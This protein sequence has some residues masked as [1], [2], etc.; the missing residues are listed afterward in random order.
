MDP[1]VQQLASLCRVQV[2]RCK[3]VF[4]P[5]HAVGRTIGERIALG[6]TNWLNLRFVTPLDIAL[7]MGAP[8]LVERGIDPSEEGLGPALIMRLLLELP[9]VSGDGSHAGGGERGRPAGA[10]LLTNA[11]GAE[12]GLGCQPTGPAGDGSCASGYFRPLADQPTMAQALWATIR[13]LRMA[14]VKSDDLRAEAFESA[15]KHA[16][17][18][19]L[20]RA[21]EQFLRSNKRGDMALVYEEALQ[22][23]DWCPIQPQDCWTELPE[24]IWTPLQRRLMDVMPGER[25]LPQ[26]IAISGMT[27]PRRLQDAAVERINADAASN[28]LAFLM[29]PAGEPRT[30][31]ANPEPAVASRVP[32]PESR[33]PSVSLFH[34][35]GR[36]AEIE[37]V[38]RRIVAGGVS[39]DQVEI[40]CASDAH[41]A[42]VWEKSLRHEWAVTLGSGIA[43]T[44]IRPG[45][46]LIGFCDWIETDFSAAHLRHLLQ[47]G[48]MGLEK[49]EKHAEGFTAGEAARTLARAE[50]GWGRA[51]YGLALGA[52]RKGYEKRA[53]DPDISEDDRE[54]ARQKAKLAAG[55]LAW[56][57]KVVSSVPEPTGSGQVSLQAVVDAALDYLDRSTAR[58]SQIDHRS[59]GALAEYIAELRALGSFSC[60]LP[61]AL[62]FIRERVQSLQVAQERPRP[63]HLYACT[64]PQM[65]YSGR[66][67]LFVVGLE[68]GGVFPSA[69][70]D[71]VLLDAEREAI[72]SA[73]R[74]SNDKIDEAV[75]FA[76]SRLATMG[77]AGALES[78]RSG[79][80]IPS[81]QSAIPTNITFSYSVRDTRE[82]RETYASWLMLQAYRL[83]QSD[84]AASYQQMKAA[85]GEPASSIPARRDAAM[86]E[87]GWWL[88]SVVGTGDP[89]VAA[90]E[91]TFTGVAGGRKAEAGRGSER[92]TEFDGYVPDAGKVLDPCAAQNAF[93]VTDLESAAAC[94]YRLF[95]KRGLGLRPVDERDRDKDV[96]LD[97]LV[98]GSELHDI[99]AAAL[100]RCRD[101]KR[102]PEQSKDGGWLRKLV[103]ERLAE[104]RQEMPPA[105]EEIFERESK[106][107]LA[108]V[109]LFLDGECG[110]S[111][112]E[113]VGFEVS[114]GRALDDE[115]EV[116]ARAEPVEIDLGGGLR[117]RVAGRIDRID[118]VGDASFEILDY[119]TGGY[120]PGD[121]TGTFKGG[122]RLQ[123]ALYGLA[124]LELLKAR[125]RK[126]TLTRGVYYFSSHK[127]GQKRVEIATPSPADMAR[128]LADLRE[129]I[130]SGTFVHTPEERDCTFCDYKAACG[131]D[132]HAQAEA[133]LED[134][135]L[136]AYRRLAAHV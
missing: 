84:P 27:T 4:V 87:A 77:D 101:A 12:D 44:A 55:V 20:L 71:P 117:F 1:F 90:V 70:E 14:G 96:W 99:Y 35:G 80:L 43:A 121:W 64:L 112:S 7:R 31:Q 79:T 100:R 59:A 53:G 42:L 122:R 10:F 41:V 19:A 115:V 67:H 3:W 66:P 104:L 74:R 68:E 78:D 76:L 47:S 58:S 9:A 118:K 109:E 30:S 51:T 111:T 127:G 49:P 93:S 57:T 65:G 107:F 119:K 102:R 17:L 23:P 13:E 50:A 123:H 33:A 124:A 37:E 60:S 15:A 134:A 110:D 103:Q 128:V 97:P 116:L 54:S 130:V 72:S 46:A 131:G 95:L 105:T 40:A 92:F 16:E 22:H 36:E 108:D 62:R 21:Y 75:Y 6:G 113:P 18:R 88:R 81:P 91:A 98:R 94:P 126:P 5:T 29:Q 48:D 129:L 24:V 11:V 52:L 106:D 85:L 73:L 135:K 28:P 69:T 34:A 38:F 125:Y 136:K 114:F 26:A 56:I 89:G 132:M 61:G 86:S 120:W 2:T 133:K 8:F 63:G 45:R 25:I 83:Q 39:L 82:F 32:S